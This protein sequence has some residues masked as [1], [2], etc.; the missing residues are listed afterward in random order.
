MTGGLLQLVAKNYDDLYMTISPQVTLFKVV[1]KR[2]SN[3]SIYD[4]DILIKSGGNFSSKTI[5]KLESNA[6]LLHKMYIVAEIPEI[7]ISKRRP[8]FAHISSILQTAGV[9]W[10][11]SS[12][13][14][15]D[16]LITIDAY[17]SSGG[18]TSISQTINNQIDFLIGNYNFFNNGIIM[19][20]DTLYTSD[21]ILKSN[22]GSIATSIIN[23]LNRMQDSSG[24]Y[25]AYVDS[26]GTTIMQYSDKY[27]TMVT[28]LISGRNCEMELLYKM[29]SSYSQDYGIS[30]SGILGS[31]FLVSGATEE[32][33]IYSTEKT[34]SL[35]GS[36]LQRQLLM[37]GILFGALK[38]YSKD[39]IIYNA[40]YSY[41][42]SGF[43]T[44][45]YLQNISSSGT[46]IF[47]DN[48]LGNVIIK[49]AVISGNLITGG[50]ITGTFVDPYMSK[51]NSSMSGIN[52]VNATISDTV[53]NIYTNYAILNCSI[54]STGTSSSS[55]TGI[56]TAGT[57]TP[58]TING[59][60]ITNAVFN[61]PVLSVGTV[62]I[63][64]VR[65]FSIK[66]N[67][68]IVMPNV[69]IQYPNNIKKVKTLYNCTLGSYLGTSDVAPYSS[70]NTTQIR[71]V[72]GTEA[73]IVLSGVKLKNFK[74]TDGRATF[75]GT[76]ETGRLI[77]NN[78][79]PANG[80]TVKNVVITD[81]QTI[82]IVSFGFTKK[83]SVVGQYTF[84]N[85]TI[86][87]FRLN[88]SKV[89]GHL[90]SGTNATFLGSGSTFTICAS[91]C[92]IT[93]PTY[94]PIVLTNGV[95]SGG[96]MYN[97]AIQD[98]GIDTGML[99][100]AFLTN[101]LLTDS[102]GTKYYNVQMDG[103]NL[104]YPS[105]ITDVNI[106]DNTTNQVYI[107]DV[108]RNAYDGSY[109]K[110]LFG[111]ILS[112]SGIKANLNGTST[113][114]LNNVPEI[115]KL[116][117][118][119]ANDFRYI[120]YISYLN[121]ITRLKIVTSG[122]LDPY[123]PT[124]ASIHKGTINISDANLH[125]LTPQL[126]SLDESILFYHIIDP[127]TTQYSVPFQNVSAY[128]TTGDYFTA[129]I[130][131]GYSIIEKYNDVVPVSRF[132][133]KT[134]D[135]YMIYSQYISA[136]NNSVTDGIVNTDDHVKYLAGNILSYIDSNIQYNFSQ[137]F[138]IL[139]ILYN[140]YRYMS[141]SYMLSFYQK[142]TLTDSGT[143][144]T[145]GQGFTTAV[146][147]L[148]NFGTI[149]SNVQPVTLT[150]TSTTITNYFGNYV[151]TQFSN[152][153]YNCKS[154][155]K[156]SGY[157]EYMNAYDIWSKNLY[158]NGNSLHTLYG[159]A[160]NSS[161]PMISST[162]FGKMSVTAFIPF[163]AAR[164]IPQMMYDIIFTYGKVIFGG[165]LNSPSFTTTNAN[166]LNFFD[167]YCKEL[168][169]YTD[170]SGMIG[171]PSAPTESEIKKA[172]YQ[173]I[174][175]S[176]FLSDKYLQSNTST[177]TTTK[178]LNDTYFNSVRT[179][180]INN[181]TDY[182][183]LFTF[184][185][186]NF[187]PPSAYNNSGTLTDLNLAGG[188]YSS[189]N[190]SEA[191]YLPIEWLTQTYYNIFGELSD[192]TIDNSILV[193]G[194][195]SM[196]DATG[197][198]NR[199]AI[200]QVMRGVIANIVN[201][202]IANSTLPSFS[203]YVTNRY[204]LLGLLPETN[205]SISL[206]SQLNTIATLGTITTPSYC[207]AISSITYQANKKFIQLYNNLFND[208]LLSESYYSQNVGVAML[209]LYEYIATQFNLADAT[210]IKYTLTNVQPKMTPGTITLANSFSEYQLDN[211]Y[212]INPTSYSQDAWTS[213]MYPAV[214]SSGGKT[215]FD[216]Y[217][218][219]NLIGSPASLPIQ[220]STTA[221]STINSFVN[222][223]KTLYLTMLNYYNE[224]KTILKIKN[225]TGSLKLPGVLPDGSLDYT[226][227]YNANITSFLYDQ[228]Q[229]INN[230][231]YFNSYIN[232]VRP[233]L[234]SPTTKLQTRGSTLANLA[235]DT[236]NH[237]IPYFDGSGNLENNGLL[238]PLDMLYG[239]VDTY[240]QP[241]SYDSSGNIDYTIGTIM[242]PA[243]SL[244]LELNK[245][246]IIPDGKSINDYIDLSL[247][248]NNPFSSFFLHDWYLSLQSTNNN[249]FDSSGQYFKYETLVNCISLFNQ[250]IGSTTNKLITSP[251][252]SSSP[253][254]ST[255]YM[256]SFGS[257]YGDASIMANVVYDGILKNVIS[258]ITKGLLGGGTIASQISIASENKGYKQTLDALRSSFQQLLPIYK[259]GLQKLTTFKDASI[260]TTLYGGN[261]Q[262]L[263][264]GLANYYSNSSHLIG[265]T[266]ETTL[267][268]AIFTENPKYAWVNELGNKLVKNVSIKIGGQL[269]DSHSSNL[270]HFINKINR[271]SSQKR[272]Y[273][274]MIG[275]TP[276]L[277][278]YSSVKRVQNKIYI[279]L[280]F[281]FNKH[282]GNALPLL[283]LLYSDV[284]LVIEMSSY[285]DLICIEPTA[286]YTQ[287]PKLKTKLFAQYI[288][289]DEE[290]RPRMAQ[291]KLEYL[292]E[293][294]NY[295]GL[296]IYSGNNLISKN[297][298]QIISKN[299]EYV[300][301]DLQKEKQI[302]PIIK[303][304]VYLNDPIKYFIWYV[305]I[306]DKTK[307]NR[308]DML[309]W[310]K[311]GYRV[312]NAQGELVEFST[313]FSSI[314]I[315]MNGT[316]R[317]E[318]KNEY[319]YTY[320]SPYGRSIS[321]IN[322]GE[323][324]YS[325][326]LYPSLLQPSGSANYSELTNSSIV[327]VLTK[328]I[329]D[330]LSN[331]P[332]IEIQMELWG[333]AYKI[334][335]VFSGF[336][337]LA[338]YK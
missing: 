76:I 62:E 71:T 283:C 256:S 40:N 295:S 80:S 328:Q 296:K 56:I 266:L 211:T 249:I 42:N 292:I 186:E 67:G 125:I 316:N 254:I 229:I 22:I 48:V 294:Y 101:V 55:I 164:D 334:L 151:Q 333:C 91:G 313:I 11:Y 128:D 119:N 50:D 41:Y 269:I 272:G 188:L 141:S 326:A 227:T 221:F 285:Q 59:I 61:E 103:L 131:S 180:Y 12:F 73:Y 10:D 153:V 99:P 274:I 265:T 197:S 20:N 134:T 231:I 289:I 189:A 140:G 257:V 195:A 336:G 220:G 218:I 102:S 233:L 112:R 108:A 90:D 193:S 183:L 84:T 66:N 6:D 16:D 318:P 277:T 303:Y 4:D 65:N 69:V 117:L 53:N 64:T 32:K 72:T 82:I 305:K 111:N 308:L 215:G 171:Q 157:M 241:L 293:S 121:N 306:T 14:L 177:S 240:G 314:S 330:I 78:V 300:V 196:W 222:D 299:K 281:W 83:I 317:E 246:A 29:F 156:N 13:G 9:T 43:I 242:Y 179:S 208:S 230:Y 187:M 97:Y 52:I 87:N 166:F 146:E 138:Q 54:T 301:T 47:Y 282:A 2:Y 335:R 26:S 279:P 18:T 169:K 142:Y 199:T 198:S 63:P 3:F 49:N 35:Y 21:N 332:N 51:Y 278:K 1:Y 207:D 192:A 323:Y 79:I 23:P 204:L 162:T 173:R 136:I 94:N 297:D 286:Y 239:T 264:R 320:V 252:L 312:R 96:T 139:A 261:N 190:A 24:S 30:Q 148:D 322:T 213:E 244:P 243:G 271:N 7:K 89:T 235:L 191:V 143:Y 85:C 110:P 194:S 251:I 122:T 27:N 217:R 168:E 200:K 154:Y 75:S 237:W 160:R 15:S 176:T 263:D 206:T 247:P 98:I 144:T 68:K 8:T 115:I 155:L 167:T 338:F 205:S 159:L 248:E 25:F 202:F 253:Y 260:F 45:G 5:V 226:I 310:N 104:S 228:S 250:A 329:A 36:S 149:L 145:E 236:M 232:Y 315:E 163:L 60:N 105:N 184:R 95:L 321:G 223:F 238:G 212:F 201:C 77:S 304:D 291:S 44:S 135:A 93:N 225:D 74:S 86:S 58:S 123:N 133:Y 181:N 203:N 216:L 270:L 307:E 172:I 152:F 161:A 19:S 219:T 259:T 39:S 100:S 298:A 258:S 324:F 210:N 309:D 182:L 88:G 113:I 33:I 287:I 311:F 165:Y 31:E 262:Y 70:T 302:S 337:A 175:Y 234:L 331:N 275:N 174:M 129:V 120:S 147:S 276:E 17:D 284:E 92:V 290:E 34:I 325:F 267:L 132:P 116:K 28:E 255:L 280:H 178:F 150:A 81:V 288:Y 118:Y 268:E 170:K 327:L 106:I 107:P 38:A 130:N 46:G 158:Q 57:L 137:L 114:Y 124:Y 185:P 273:D 37:S 224:H 127:E 109:S 126:L 209:S 319:Y 245:L 214:D